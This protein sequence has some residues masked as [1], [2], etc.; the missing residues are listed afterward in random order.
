MAPPKKKPPFDLM[1]INPKDMSE[2][3]FE[4]YGKLLKKE[5]RK[6]S[7]PGATLKEL[8]LDDPSN[9]YFLYVAKKQQVCELIIIILSIPLLL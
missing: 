4:D 2:D 5:I 8:D 7:T 6:I 1:K 3:E 9:S